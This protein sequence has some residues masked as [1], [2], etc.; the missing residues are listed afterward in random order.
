M[1]NIRGRSFDELTHV[2]YRGTAQ[3]TPKRWSEGFLGKIKKWRKAIT[4]AGIREN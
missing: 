4:G 1:S 2:S 3:S